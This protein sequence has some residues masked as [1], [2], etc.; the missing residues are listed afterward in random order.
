[1]MLLW[2]VV[3]VTVWLSDRINCNLW[4]SIGFPYLH[5]LW[6]I[7]AFLASSIGCV[8][9]AYLHASRE[10]PQL[11]PQIHYWPSNLFEHG[12]PYVYIKSPMTDRYSS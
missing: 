11:K 3:A 10:V 2:M 7:F 12:V 5:S 4:L 1:M 8:L 6:H 9:C